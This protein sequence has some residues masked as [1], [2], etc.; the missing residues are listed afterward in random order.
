VVLAATLLVAPFIAKAQVGPQPEDFQ[1][2]LSHATLSV[3]QGQQVCKY[4]PYESFFGTVNIWGCK[5][6]RVFTC[7]A[8]VIAQE[9]D[10]TYIGL[11]AGHCIDWAKEND[12]FVG[13]SVAADGVLHN[14]HIVKS[15]NDARYDFVLFEFHSLRSL[16]TIQ[17]AKE[18][19]TPAL[20]TKVIN[21]NFA[22]G[23]GKQFTHGEVYSET[24]EEERL[25]MKERF[26]IT[27]GTGPGASG[28]AIVDEQTH[29]IIGLCEFGMNRGQLGTGVIPT[30][31]RFVDF[32]DD[33]SAGLKPKPEP[34]A[35]PVKAT[36]E[37]FLSK[38]LE[39][40]RRVI[41]LS[42]GI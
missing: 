30:G 18:G 39:V 6:E 22:M 41:N 20:G 23:I 3:Y 21:I 5:F 32:M 42:I 4:T 25:G 26:L 31:K 7:T 24:L 1:Q 12:Y 19:G 38:F 27:N 37:S 2:T 17:V 10:D 33:E 35:P 28:S 36:A 14:I 13:S 15:E 11:S 29:E 40:I 9:S 8:T 34:V 16:P